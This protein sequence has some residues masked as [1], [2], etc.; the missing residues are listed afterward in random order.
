MTFE[1]SVMIRSLD[2]QKT[3]DVHAEHDRKSKKIQN[4]I[5]IKNNSSEKN[6]TIDKTKKKPSYRVKR[7]TWFEKEEFDNLLTLFQTH[8][9]KDFPK[10][11]VVNTIPTLSILK[12][13]KKEKKIQIT[14]LLLSRF[15]HQYVLIQR[16]KSLTI[17]TYVMLLELIQSHYPKDFSIDYTA[18]PKTSIFKRI[19]NEKKV[20]IEAL[21]L[22]R[23]VNQYLKKQKDFF[24]YRERKDKKILTTLQTHYP[25]AFPKENKKLLKLGIFEDIKNEGKIHATDDDLKAFLNSYTKSVDYLDCYFTAPVRHDLKGNIVAPTTNQERFFAKK[26]LKKIKNKNRI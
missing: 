17:K 16:H 8:Y 5:V 12:V 9:P 19:K 2:D 18:M 20:D 6:A 7:A 1:Q 3:R 14:D 10:K 23:F 4:M 13:I 21:T 22:R 11:K 24:I 26:T 15:L 25:I